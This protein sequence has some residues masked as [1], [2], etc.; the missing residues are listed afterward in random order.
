[1]NR[2]HVATVV[3]SHGLRGEI[4]VRVE[5]EN[6]KRFSAGRRLF[7]GESEREFH[8]VSY[9][10]NGLFG[11]LKL[12]EIADRDAADAL[13]GKTLT[14][15]EEE[16]PEPEDGKFYVKDLI[17]SEVYDAEGNLRGVLEDV[18]SYASNDVYVVRGDSGETLVPA[19]KSVVRSVDVK[20]K[21]I[22]LYPLKGLFDAN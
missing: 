22:N 15:S 12:Q 14:V 13:R 16:L 2:I 18:L 17:G 5:D 1:M 10:G 6:P 19:L 11:I 7:L 3:A 21:R 20:A 4:K 9:R 8:V